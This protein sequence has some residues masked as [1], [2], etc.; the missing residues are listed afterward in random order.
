MDA[1]S[2]TGTV[3]PS[4]VSEFTPIFK[5]IRVVLKHITE[6]KLNYLNF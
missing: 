4:G 5:G 6:M 1:S 2:G 3:Y